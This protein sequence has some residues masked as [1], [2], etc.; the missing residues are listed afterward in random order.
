VSKVL[1]IIQ[2]VDEEGRKRI[3]TSQVND[4][5][6]RAARAAPAVAGCRPRGEAQLRDAG[7]RPAADDRGV[8]E[9]SDLVEEHYV[10]FLHNGFRESWQFMGNPLRILMRRKGGG[11]SAD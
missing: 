11:A 5:A 8:R 9:S 7:E 10:R 1:D 2:L 6:G 4:A 3:P